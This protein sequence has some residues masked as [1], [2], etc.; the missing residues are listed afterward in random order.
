MVTKVENLNWLH[1]NNETFFFLLEAKITLKY[2]ESFEK[3]S[4]AF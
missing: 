4:D 1:D 3:K 2:R